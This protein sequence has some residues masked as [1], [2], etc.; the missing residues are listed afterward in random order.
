MLRARVGFSIIF[1]F[2]YLTLSLGSLGNSGAFAGV[3]PE[4]ARWETLSWNE[5]SLKME[6]V[7]ETTR[8][9]DKLTLAYKHF[10]H[11]GAQPVLLIHGLAQNDR[12]W[13][14][15]VP[16]Y[17]FARFLHAQGFDV[18][19][20]NMRNAGTP[21]FRSESPS[22]PRHWTIDDYAVY[23][24]PALV[25]GV[26][27][28]TG[29]APF[30]LAHSL[31]AWAMEGYLAG[32]TYDRDGALQPSLT[33]SS[34]RQEQIRGL[35]TIAGVY[36]L[37][38]PKSLFSGQG[39]PLQ[40]EDDYY[41]SNFE[42]ELLASAKFLY[43]IIP[44]L[45]ALPLD[46]IGKVLNAPLAEIPLIGEMF[47]DELCRLYQGLQKE[48]IQT[49]IL[50]MLYYP[51]NSDPETVRLHG[52]DGLE[53]LGPHLIEQLAN[54]LNE[55]ET[56]SYFHIDRKPG[57]YRYSSVRPRVQVPMLFVAGGR[58]RLANAS[59][60]YRDGYEGTQTPDKQFLGVDLN[61][62]LDIMNGKNSNGEVM[63][64]VADWLHAHE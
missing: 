24:I 60:I 21:G 15:A 38:W 37:W 58:D 7:R 62:H 43:R 63:G 9:N 33:I 31:A 45:P 49:P 29:K 26:R 17:S 57:L 14:A 12:G 22:G 59:M 64:P 36:N 28:K 27:E 50:S 1:S 40:S 20:G 51:A 48:I 19:V 30:V 11:P 10:A 52:K 2:F 39:S 56:L 3:S 4:A 61:G 16:K 44:Q 42:L 25:R 54:A 5:P 46:W 18:W 23:D 32:L 41:Q 35:V 13:D 47:G 6:P 55:H 53:D 34:T 8:T